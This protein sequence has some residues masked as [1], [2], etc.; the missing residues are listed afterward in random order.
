MDP[1]EHRQVARAI[2][3][4]YVE[5]EAIFG[6]R[7]HFPRIDAA[8]PAGWLNAGRARSQCVVHALAARHRHG[9]APTSF[10]DWRQRIGNAAIDAEAF[11]PRATHA[12][13]GKAGDRRRV[14]TTETQRRLPADARRLA[15]EQAMW[16]VLPEAPAFLKASRI[17]GPRQPS[18]QYSLSR[19][20]IS[21]EHRYPRASPIT[22]AVRIATRA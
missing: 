7:C 9:R 14:F 12:A 19:A 17:N 4:P 16:M 5:G 8:G 1:D 21:L 13:I 6:G 18:S 22:P 2:G 15:A 20:L 3:R 11:E 10:S